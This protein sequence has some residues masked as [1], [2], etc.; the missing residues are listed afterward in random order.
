M[1]SAHP[2]RPRSEALKYLTL[3]AGTHFDPDLVPLFIEVLD[4]RMSMLS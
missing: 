2:A 3:H 4:E 1:V